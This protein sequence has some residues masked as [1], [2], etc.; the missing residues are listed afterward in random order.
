MTKDST[1]Y[2][3]PGDVYV[4]TPYTTITP[5]SVTVTEDNLVPVI[6][7]PTGTLRDDHRNRYCVKHN[8]Y[9]F[10]YNCYGT[11]YFYLPGHYNVFF[12][13]AKRKRNEAQPTQAQYIAKISCKNPVYIAVVD[14]PTSTA[15]TETETAP[16]PTF[17]SINTISFTTTSPVFDTTTT[18]A[19]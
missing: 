8:Y 6:A 15:E 13:I 2:L 14:I 7:T 9:H 11:G 10:A 1:I 16:T 17:T 4:K 19:T 18:T 3:D 5:A 12:V